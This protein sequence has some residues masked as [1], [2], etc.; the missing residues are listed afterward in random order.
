MLDDATRSDLEVLAEGLRRNEIQKIDLTNR[1]IGFDGIRILAEAIEQCENNTNLDTL[2]LD[3]NDMDD[4]CAVVLNQALQQCTTALHVLSLNNN[5]IGADGAIILAD[6][7]STMTNLTE[8]YLEHNMIGDEGTVALAEA[9]Q[10]NEAL[11]LLTL[12][13]NS[14]GD[15]G[16]VAL[17]QA[18]QGLPSLTGL[19]LDG[20]SIGANGAVALADALQGKEVL[21]ALNY[22]K[23]ANG[24]NNDDIPTSTWQET[25]TILTSLFTPS[26]LAFAKV[27]QIKPSVSVLGLENNSIGDRGAVALA[28]GFQEMTSLKKLYLAGNSIGNVG[29]IAFSEALQAKSTLAVLG[30]ENNFV[31]DRGAFALARALKTSSGLSELNLHGN[32]VSIHGA[33]A[34]FESLKGKPVVSRV[35]AEIKSLGYSGAVALAEGLKGTIGLQELTLIGNS[36]GADGTV[37]LAEA[38]HDKTTVSVLR[39]ENNFICDRGAVALAEA[40]LGMKNLTSLALAGNS[41]SVKGAVALAEALQENTSVSLVGLENNLIGDNGAI[42]VANVLEGMTSLSKLDISANQIG[43]AGAD[44]FVHVLQ[45]SQSVSNLQELNMAEN[46]IATATMDTISNLMHDRIQLQTGLEELDETSQDDM[47]SMETEETLESLTP[48]TDSSVQDEQELEE[49][50]VFDVSSELQK[51]LELFEELR[52]LEDNSVESTVPDDES[53][54]QDFYDVAS[55]LQEALQSLESRPPVEVPIEYIKNTTTGLSRDGYVYKAYD[56]ANDCVYTVEK[57]AVDEQADQKIESLTKVDHPQV[58]RLLGFSRTDNDGTYLV[59]QHAAGGSLANILQGNEN[60]MLAWQNRASTLLEVAQALQ[61]CFEQGVFH[62]SLTVENISF[63]DSEYRHSLLTGLGSVSTAPAYVAPESK[64]STSKVLNESRE[65]YSFGVTMIA[66]VVGETRTDK[67]GEIVEAVRCNGLY[68]NEHVDTSGGTWD[69]HALDKICTVARRCV[70]VE[71]TERPTIEDIL[72]ELL[73]L[74]TISENQVT[75]LLSEELVTDFVA[76]SLECACG[77]NVCFSCFRGH[78]FCEGCLER[79]VEKQL[80]CPEIACGKD[81]CTEVFTTE[82]LKGC[83]SKATLE[84]RAVTPKRHG[85]RQ[86]ETKLSDQISH[87]FMGRLMQE[88]AKQDIFRP[89]RGE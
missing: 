38:L 36:I 33:T 46:N 54:D 72:H 16:A 78:S 71:S 82:D 44:A 61:H 52:S 66:L 12:A 62:Q 11:S 32:A 4:D 56:A 27:W 9:L 15:R 26:A 70:Q 88:A 74:G 49:D 43:D 67:L 29:A 80:F 64:N 47:K 51:A 81:G 14:I 48:T 25:M 1:Q 55:A 53:D 57:I 83:V 77:E 68:M 87:A 39:L 76:P 7:L 58:A 28:K 79:L 8:L 84:A 65:V 73:P 10:D 37:A 35:K 18:L 19:Y 75:E 40:I 17:A 89:E 31:G 85:H 6:S 5:S 50:Q 59:Y 20:N 23:I 69:T 60:R 3:N 63:V 45:E 34:F 86:R 30:L 42:A 22:E 2:I 21:S 13:F 24:E 41:I